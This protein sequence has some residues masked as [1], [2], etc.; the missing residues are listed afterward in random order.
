[1]ANAFQLMFAIAA[2]TVAAAPSAPKV[3]YSPEQVIDIR[4]AGY[5]MSAVVFGSLK[6]AADEGVEPKTQG[7]FAGGLAQ[8]AKVVPTLFP[9]GTA[10]GETA[11]DTQA[12]P[13]IWTNRT[14]FERKAAAF[15]AAANKIV[16]ATHA[17]DAAAFKASIVEVKKTCDACHA[18]YKQRTM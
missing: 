7:F 17:N 12:K 4:H 8:W 1:M 10:I 14:D 2:A 5:E 9:Q 6:K 16:E 11:L 13:E 3:S 15:L 18:D